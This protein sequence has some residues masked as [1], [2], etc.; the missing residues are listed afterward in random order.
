MAVRHDRSDTK[1][2]GG[3]TRSYRKIKKYDLGSEFSSPE[4]GDQRIENRD[5]RG[6]VTKNVVRRENQMNLS[7]DGE[8]ESVEIEAVVDNPAN[9]NYV[10]RSLLTKGTIVET[11]EGKARVSSRPGQEGV[12]NGVLVE[13]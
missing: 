13:E 3:K 9:D 12:V 5:S 6:N 10:R 11:S 2:S 7:V 1:K 8:V 4:L